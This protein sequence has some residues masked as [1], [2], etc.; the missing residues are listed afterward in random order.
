MIISSER[1]IFCRD[2][3]SVISVTD[4]HIY[5]I[6]EHPLT[7]NLK[8]IMRKYLSLEMIILLKED[9]TLP[10]CRVVNTQVKF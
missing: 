1:R 10:R 5:E 3:I 7:S 2:K 6:L 4:I 8:H 9:I